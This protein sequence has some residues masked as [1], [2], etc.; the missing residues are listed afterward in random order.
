KQWPATPCLRGRKLASEMSRR[1]SPAPEPVS[2]R[3]VCPE[4]GSSLTLF[5]TRAISSSNLE[6]NSFML[7]PG[8]SLAGIRRT[9]RTGLYGVCCDSQHGGHAPAPADALGATN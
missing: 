4:C 6:R 2:G 8:S 1:L 5:D 9:L 3:F 7:L